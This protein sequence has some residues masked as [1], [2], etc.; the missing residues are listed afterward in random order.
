MKYLL[1]VA[2]VLSMASIAKAQTDEFGFTLTNDP[3]PDFSCCGTGLPVIGSGIITVGAQAAPSILIQSSVLPFT[4]LSLTGTFNG[5]AMSLAPNPYPFSAGN[6]LSTETPANGGLIPTPV[7]FYAPL[8]FTAD[9]SQWEIYQQDVPSPG[10]GEIL[11][12]LSNPNISADVSLLVGSTNSVV[13]VPEPPTLELLAMGLLGVIGL[14]WWRN[15]RA[16]VS[17]D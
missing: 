15:K 4:I 1:V 16:Y 5:S 12:D 2:L 13:P 8:Y 10:T 9:G 6:L 3:S 11:E 14:A 7:P 17:G